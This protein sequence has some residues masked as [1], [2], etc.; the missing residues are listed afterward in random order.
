MLYD[1]TII[2]GSYAGL[3]AAMPLA[4]ARRNIAIIDAGQRRNRFAEHSHG[5]L[6]QDGTRA[7]EIVEI[8]KNQLEA[9]STV[10]WKNGWVKQIAKIDEGFCICIDGVVSIQTKKL[11]L[12]QELTI[13]CRKY[14]VWLRDGEKRFFIA[15][16]A[17][18]MNYNKGKSVFWPLLSTACNWR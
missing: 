4:R 12:R 8:A 16:I 3:S 18:D 5:F 14:L 1:V 2:G 9:Y 15:H 7:S 17:M 10:H 6:T 11:L 13:S